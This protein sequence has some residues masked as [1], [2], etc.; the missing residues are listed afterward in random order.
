[1]LPLKLHNYYLYVFDEK[2]KVDLL[3]QQAVTA[4]RETKGNLVCRLKNK[5]VSPLKTLIYLNT[6]KAGCSYICLPSSGCILLTN[7]YLHADMT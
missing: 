2:V 3:D 6:F 5:C 1:M 7:V 4:S